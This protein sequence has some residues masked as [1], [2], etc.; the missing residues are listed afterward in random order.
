VAFGR[1]SQ[2]RG[3]T[4]TGEPRPKRQPVATSAGVARRMKIKLRLSAFRFPSLFVRYC[5]SFFRLFLRTFFCHCR[6]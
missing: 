1:L 4:P 5:R 6:A 2:S 3:G